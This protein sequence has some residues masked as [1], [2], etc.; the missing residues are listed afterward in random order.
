MDC[1]TRYLWTEPIPNKNATTVKNAFER[2][3]KRAKS[4]PHKLWTDMGGEFYNRVLKSYLK[5]HDIEL[6]STYN[7]G[8]AVM[9]ERVIRTIK[10]KMYRMRTDAKKKTNTWKPLLIQAVNKYNDSV[11]SS[12]RV[13]PTDAYNDP[14]IIRDVASD[15]NF[16]NENENK[17]KQ[18]KFKVGDRVRIFKFKTQFEKGYTAKWTSE[19]FIVSKVIDTSPVTYQIEDQ[20]GEPILGKFYAEE[21]QKTE[22]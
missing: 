20:G 2:I 10:E 18:Y 21:L 22:Y 9:A 12:I 14:D 5:E 16:K 3:V 1:Y 6:Y 17:P 13:T 7:E 4:T 11:H 19:I 8:K 15:N